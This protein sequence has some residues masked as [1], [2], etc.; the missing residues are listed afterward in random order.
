MNRR[1]A[2][3]DEIIAREHR[4]RHLRSTTVCSITY[5]ALRI[6]LANCVRLR[7]ERTEPSQITPD[8]KHLAA[9]DAE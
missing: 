9:G 8:G 6:C 7:Q 3:S 5:P 1:T 2:V 4:L